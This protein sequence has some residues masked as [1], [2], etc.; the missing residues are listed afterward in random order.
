MRKGKSYSGSVVAPKRYMVYEFDGKWL[1]SA[2]RPG[3]KIIKFN[4]KLEATNFVAGL[5]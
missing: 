2:N 4:N 1:V 5:K 3:A